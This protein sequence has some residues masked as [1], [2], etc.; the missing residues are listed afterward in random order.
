MAQ[1]SLYLVI[2][3]Q[4]LW[5]FNI[6]EVKHYQRHLLTTIENNCSGDPFDLVQKNL[7]KC[8]CELKDF[9]LEYEWY[10]GSYEVILP[11]FFIQLFI[12]KENSGKSRAFWCNILDEI[13]PKYHD[14]WKFRTRALEKKSFC[15]QT[16]FQAKQ[17]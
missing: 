1:R 14:Y 8:F 6:D 9:R 3:P 17:M 4:V 16:F 7:K 5:I 11:N 10:H 12:E 2:C 15:M 13:F